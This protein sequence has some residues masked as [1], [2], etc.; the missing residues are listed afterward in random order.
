MLGLG[1]PRLKSQPSLLDLVNGKREL[2]QSPPSPPPELPPLPD[3]A[4][5]TSSTSLTTSST[6]PVSSPVPPSSTKLSSKMA[7]A[8]DQ[9]PHGSIFS[10]SGPV[11]VAEN[12][13]GCAMYELVGL[14]PPPRGSFPM[15]RQPIAHTDSEIVSAMSDTTRWSVK[16]SVSMETRLPFRSTKKPVR[17]SS[18][19]GPRMPRSVNPHHHTN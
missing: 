6:S 10:V 11:V 8:K 19:R 1:K 13:I 2:E 14:P 18:L 4:V 5:P 9:E 17:P 3:S 15:P 16:S 12:M 7:P